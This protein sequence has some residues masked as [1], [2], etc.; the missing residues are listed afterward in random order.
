[1]LVRGNRI[2][3]RTFRWELGWGRSIS[4]T[5][6]L[7]LGP[8]RSLELRIG[9]LSLNKALLPCKS[10]RKTGFASTN[11]NTSYDQFMINSLDQKKWRVIIENLEWRAAINSVSI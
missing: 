8:L 11:I 6:A 1:M 9:P 10:R 2:V 7:A 3:F 4:L 5:S